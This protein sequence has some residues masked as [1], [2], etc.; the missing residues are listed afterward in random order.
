MVTEQEKKIVLA[1]LA[2]MPLDLE[3]SLGSMGSFDRNKLI[4]EVE[5]NSDVGELVVEVYMGYLRSFKNKVD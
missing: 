3:L 4:E 2:T 5:A 1:R